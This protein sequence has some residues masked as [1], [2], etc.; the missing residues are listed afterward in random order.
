MT[1]II[2]ARLPTLPEILWKTSLSW[3]RLFNCMM[4][5]QSIRKLDRNASADMYVPSSNILSQLLFHC[6]YAPHKQYLEL[7]N[8]ANSAKTS[9]LMS[10]S[11][12]SSLS[13]HRR[14]KAFLTWRS[15][16]AS[17]S[18]IVIAL[19]VILGILEVIFHVR[20][21]CS[22]K[23]VKKYLFVNCA[24]FGVVKVAWFRLAE[25]EV[26]C[27]RIIFTTTKNSMLDRTLTT[28]ITKV[29]WRQPF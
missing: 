19:L 12:L 26:I 4:H 7:F 2:D 29:L 11:K 27:Q 1:W 18:F 8:R 10:S 23:K 14:M 17:Y 6:L 22:R 3:T 25:P 13:K 16:R 20:W 15:A 28:P 9:W 5:A 24:C 21:V